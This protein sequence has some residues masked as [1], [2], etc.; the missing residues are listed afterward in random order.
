MRSLVFGIIL[1]AGC[2]EGET[3][4]AEQATTAPKTTEAKTKAKAKVEEPPPDLAAMTPEES[5]AYL[6]KEGE[7]IYKTGGGSGVACMT[8]HQANGKGTP[9][10]FPPLVGQKDHMGDCE[11]HARL[12]IE[13][14]TGEIVVDGQKYN[15]VMPPQPTLSNLEIAAVTTY[16]RQSW[17]NDYGVCLPAAAAAAR[18]K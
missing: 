2:S 16:V 5:K 7:N 4:P 18:A 3:S 10:A 13:G 15:S 6:M 8:C 11:N 14:L 17:G 9:G 12:I 1:I